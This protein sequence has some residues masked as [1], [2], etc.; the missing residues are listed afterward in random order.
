MNDNRETWRKFPRRAFAAALIGLAAPGAAQA[1]LSLCNQSFDVLNI[2]LAEADGADV[3]IVSSDKDLMQLVTENVSMYD[4]MKD[5][6]ISIPEVVEKWGV[7]PDKMYPLD[8]DRAFKKLEEIKPAISV[9][10][11]SGAQS[12]QLLADGEADMVMAWNGRVSAVKVE[13]APVD[14][15]II[16]ECCNIPRCAS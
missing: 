10:W 12:A 1:S 9:W 8:V 5:K 13:G 2:A 7:T 11:T 16:R 4:S 6:Q 15:T 3:T 14:F